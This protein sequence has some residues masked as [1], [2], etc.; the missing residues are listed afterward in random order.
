MQNKAFLFQEKSTINPFIKIISK[1]CLQKKGKV[2]LERI[3]KKLA[4][5]SINK[6]KHTMK[7]MIN[8]W[9]KKEPDRVNTNNN[10]M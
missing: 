2:T 7:I 4:N 1:G 8:V 5:I 10:N 9:F 3:V 6:N